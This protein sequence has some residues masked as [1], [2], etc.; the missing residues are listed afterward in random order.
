LAEIL[1]SHPTREFDAQYATDRM[2]GNGFVTTVYQSL[3]GKRTDF[4]PPK[5]G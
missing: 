1:A 3:A 5:A 2:D 4:H